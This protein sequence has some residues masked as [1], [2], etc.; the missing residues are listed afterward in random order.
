MSD[1]LKNSMRLWVGT[2]VGFGLFWAV[3]HFDVVPNIPDH[4]LWTMLGIVIALNVIRSIWDH[5]RRRKV[6]VS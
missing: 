6:Q 4:W 2:L 3:M 5:V 1:D